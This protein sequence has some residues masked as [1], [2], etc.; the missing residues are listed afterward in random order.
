MRVK[1]YIV[2]SMPSAL[3]QIR[4]ELGDQAVI[5]NTKEIKSGGFLGM[6][7]KRRLEV[8]AAARSDQDIPLKKKAP[9]S[10]LEKPVQPLASK[11]IPESDIM[12]EL[13]GMKEMLAG[14]MS[15]EGSKE[16]IPQPLIPWIGRLKEQEVDAEVIQFFKEQIIRTAPSMMEEEVEKAMVYHLKKLLAEGSL[17]EPTLSSSVNLV[18]FVGP[19][20]VGKTTTIAKLA[21][22]Q[23]LHHNRRVG[24]LT[25][26]T[27]RIA[28]VEQLKTY[29]NILNIPIETVFSPDG[30]KKAIKNLQDCDLIFMDTTGRNYQEEYFIEEIG[31]YLQGPLVQ[32]NYLVLSM[33]SKYSDMKRIVEN[34]QSVPIDKIIMTKLDETLSYGSLVNLM[35]HYPYPVAYLTNGQNVPEDITKVSPDEIASLVLGVE[36]RDYGPSPA[37]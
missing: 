33:T 9:E 35:Y 11:S 37:S 10:Q 1:K 31:K 18:S 28:A 24:L 20:G 23:V 36:H 19:T 2:D 6:F 25:T 27:Y 12:K 16:K 5:L 34:F 8:I 32:E 26:D 4:V 13:K 30:L 29:A 14:M 21:S 3:Q 7:G 15:G 22:E 17:E